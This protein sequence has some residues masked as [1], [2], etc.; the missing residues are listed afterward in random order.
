MTYKA[1]DHITMTM[2]CKADNPRNFFSEW[3]GDQV[4]LLAHLRE[5]ESVEPT[6]L[7]TLTTNL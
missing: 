7:Y 1:A 3:V 6:L 2:T 5:A 4:K